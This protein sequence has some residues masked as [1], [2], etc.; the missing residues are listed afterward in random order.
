MWLKAAWLFRL[1]LKRQGLGFK[2]GI[3]KCLG[4]TYGIEMKPQGLGLEGSGT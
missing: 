2:K 3:R 1:G 4:L